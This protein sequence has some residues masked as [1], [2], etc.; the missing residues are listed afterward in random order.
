VVD[1]AH[2]TEPV[3]RWFTQHRAQ[4]DDAATPR[5]PAGVRIRPRKDNQLAACS[6]LLGLVSAENGYPLPRPV[7]ARGWL[8]GDEV[9]AAWI[10]E[11]HGRIQGHVAI[12]RV[13]SDPATAF[14]WREVTGRPASELVGVSRL[15]VRSSVRGQGLGSAMLEAAVEESRARG[16]MPVAEMV[17]TSRRGIGL[18]ERAGWRMAAMYPSGKRGE[19]LETYLYVAPPAGARP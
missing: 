15:F 13:D 11:Q 17:S 6:R 7:S 5:V 4:S 18:Y 10:A 8:T 19:G 12:T 2:F 9:L 16:L 3:Q 14:R 1:V